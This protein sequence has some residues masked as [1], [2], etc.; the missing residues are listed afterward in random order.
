M[1]AA[2]LDLLATGDAVLRTRRYGCLMILWT[3]TGEETEGW[4]AVEPTGL[5]RLY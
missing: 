5:R 4:F 1:T 2:L 3:R